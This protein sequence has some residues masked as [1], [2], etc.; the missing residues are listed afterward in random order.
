MQKEEE[1]K[2]T[3]EVLQL[4]EAN[5]AFLGAGVT[6]QGY[7]H[8]RGEKRFEDERQKLFRR[9]PHAV[10]HSAALAG[11]HAFLRAEYAGVPLL[12]TRDDR[13]QAQAFVNACRHRGMELVAEEAGC[14]R[15]FTCPYHA[16]TYGSD[17]ELLAAPHF[18]QGFGELDKAEL[19]LHRLACVE[20]FGFI[21]V[22]IDASDEIQFDDYFAPIAADFE[23]LNIAELGVAEETVLNL[24]ANWKLLVE[25]GLEAY[26][27]KVAHKNT[28]GPFFENNLSTYQV[29]G[30]HL[31]SVLPRTSL[32]DSDTSSPDFRL[33][34]HANLLY[35]MFPNTQ[36]LVQQDHLIWI[37]ANP[38]ATDCTE[39]RLRTL[40]PAESLGQDELREY[41][42]KNH[43][44]TC[45][46]LRED[47]A[48]AEGIQRSVQAGLDQSMI[49][50]RFESGLGAFNTTVSRRLAS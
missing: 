19:G 45:A 14:A 50:G 24:K 5:S 21:W 44:I 9:L 38:L 17:G 43:A 7:D 10:A 20:R 22:T 8:Y 11:S 35:L 15:R 49:F 34:D 32:A 47:F 1:L 18:E 30:D 27:F 31:R 33:L 37:Q 28:I 42:K 29:L 16:W 23:A 40:A 48:I 6:Q 46:T 2:L 25:G 4:K 36:F 3:E 39:L 41:W 26:H 13:G 12:L